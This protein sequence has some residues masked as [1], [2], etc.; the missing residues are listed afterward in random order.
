MT[1]LDRRLYLGS[2][3]AAPAC[4]LSPW[5]TPFQTYLLKVGD[6]TEQPTNIPMRAGTFLQPFIGQ[7]FERETGL[8]C[9]SLEKHFVHP[10]HP[11]IQCHADYLADEGDETVVVECKSSGRYFSNLPIQYQV[12]IQQQLACSGLRRAYAPV[13]FA[14]NTLKVFEVEAD[15]IVQG[16]IIERMVWLWDCVQTRTAPPLETPEDVRMKWP[17]DDGV[18]KKANSQ[19]LRIL[20][21]LI[22]TRD[23][24]KEMEVEKKRL[25]SKVQ[26]FM[27]K[28]SYLVD[29]S[30]DRLAAWKQ[31]KTSKRFDAK[32]FQTENPDLAECYSREVEGSRRFTIRGG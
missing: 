8:V 6:E 22:E 18:E 13:L 17:N 32:R 21:R 25:E 7:E 16:H 4:G 29:Q 27:A 10:D 30:G 28:A 20:E 2:A 5:R 24:I 19:T 11:F 3:D 26:M 15:T 23:A 9:H 14:G 1:G 12:Q 31:P